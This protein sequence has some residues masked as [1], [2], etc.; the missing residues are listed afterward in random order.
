[1]PPITF[2]AIGVS[3]N[4]GS[5]N[6][7]KKQ[8]EV[9]ALLEQ[10]ADA[11]IKD[12][13]SR[14]HPTSGAIVS[15]ARTQE[16]LRIIM[17]SNSLDC[18]ALDGCVEF[19]RNLDIEDNELFSRARLGAIQ[20]T[21]RRRDRPE[22]ILSDLM[23]K[24]WFNDSKYG[25]SATVSFEASTSLNVQDAVQVW[26]MLQEVRKECIVSNRT[27]VQIAPDDYQIN[28]SLSVNNQFILEQTSPTRFFNLKQ[29]EDSRICH[30]YCS[31]QV[32]GL[33]SDNFGAF[34]LAAALLGG[35]PGS[36]LFEH[37][38]ESQGLCYRVGARYLAYQPCGLIF[39]N[40]ITNPELALP[41]L[42][43]IA[44][45]LDILATERITSLS[46]EEKKNDLL[47]KARL[48]SEDPIALLNSYINGFG[49][50][51]EDPN[52]FWTRS[53]E[54]VD[55]TSAQELCANTFCKEKMA[56][57]SQVQS[58]FAPKIQEWLE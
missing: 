11:A 34:T 37:L 50:T 23:R 32:G 7:T 19:I 38:R 14:F 22:L 18:K 30:I 28:H 26:S 3:F 21:N 16:D 9:I 20:Q 10:Y 55:V 39:L 56:I 51:N 33:Q 47:E 57:T 8:F 29:N 42:N 43:G 52:T 13:L 54:A 36:L 24:Q 49:H 25:Y 41:L 58:D 12:Y 40:T 4:F 35:G 1:M 53:L 5:M 2:A 45:C 17:Y 46:L 48:A 15:T 31:F 6:L 44:L 27:V